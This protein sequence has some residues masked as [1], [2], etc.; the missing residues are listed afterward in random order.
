MTIPLTTPLTS[1]GT[2]FGEMARDCFRRGENRANDIFCDS[3]D[4]R[5]Y[6]GR[7]GMDAALFTH[8]S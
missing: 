7:L 2:V 1:I 3:I 5:K 8:S 6:I 4:C